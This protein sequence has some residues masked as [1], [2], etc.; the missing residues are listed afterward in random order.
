M[1]ADGV[2]LSGDAAALAARAGVLVHWISAKGEPVSAAGEDVAA[3]LALLGHDPAGPGGARG[4]LA[5]LEEADLNEVL[6]PVQ[7]AWDGRFLVPTPRRFSGRAAELWL[8]TED[9]RRL[10]AEPGTLLECGLGVHELVLNLSDR[11]VRTTVIA[12]PWVPWSPGP[13]QDRRWGLFAPLY[14]LTQHAGQPFGDLSDLSA[15]FDWLHPRGGTVVVTLPLLAAWLDAPAEVS[16]YSPISRRAWNELYVDVAALDPSA[17]PPADRSEPFVDYD[18]AWA[19]R[20]PLLWRAAEDFFAG[21][22]PGDPRYQRFLVDR[23]AIERYARFR[24]AT[25][26]LGRNWREWPASARAGTLTAEQIDAD[27]E[28]FHLFAQWTMHHQLGEL[29]SHVEARGQLLALDLALG[30]NPSGFDVWDRQDLFVEGASVGAPPDLFFTRGQDWGFPP[31]HPQRSR[32]DGHRYFRECLRHHF[33]HA[34][35]L[36]IDT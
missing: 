2:A 34:G 1:T 4:A 35:L 5:R 10:A 31:I 3:T 24:G 25:A 22:G 17:A 15:L 11:T 28:R 7:V 20:R 16:P 19:A 26:R 30:A 23:P 33:D 9:G 29:A 12:A 27:H 14:G 32:L 18:A 36:R 13:G 21:P 6:P 8:E